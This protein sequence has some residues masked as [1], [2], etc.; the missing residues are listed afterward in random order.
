M[1]TC[2]NE[3]EEIKLL[4]KWRSQWIT[5]LLIRCTATIGLGIFLVT[6]GPTNPLGAWNAIIF[7][8]FPILIAT[9]YKLEHLPDSVSLDGQ[10]PDPFA[11]KSTRVTNH[12]Q[13]RLVRKYMYYG[14]HNDGSRWQ[15]FS[16]C[17]EAGSGALLLSI[18]GSFLSLPRPS[19]YIFTIIFSA[20]A[21]IVSFTMS[22][23]GTRI[24]SQR[25]R[26]RARE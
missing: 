4:R 17:L 23:I 26:L 14:R 3:E 24:A 11:P 19:N 20:V 10:R 15:S 7:V 5:G 13:L 25:K 8:L 16:E 12:N 18:P 21:I 1:K 22:P 6:S 9:G 2:L